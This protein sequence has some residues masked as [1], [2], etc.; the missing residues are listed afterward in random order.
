[1]A[2][3]KVK[4]IYK[5]QGCYKRQCLDYSVDR[6]WVPHRRCD[7]SQK[8]SSH[9]L[10]R[11]TNDCPVCHKSFSRSAALMCHIR[12]NHSYMLSKKTGEKG[13]IRSLKEDVMK[14][15][16]RIQEKK[17]SVSYDE[18]AIDVR[19]SGTDKDSGSEVSTCSSGKT[20]DGNEGD[21]D[22][23]SDDFAI[24]GGSVTSV[25][26]PSSKATSSIVSFTSSN[27]ELL[28]PDQSF[29]IVR[30]SS[31][32]DVK[33]KK[34]KQHRS[35]TSFNKDTFNK[36]NMSC[37]SLGIKAALDFASID[38]SIDNSSEDQKIF[39]C[40][41]C[42]D[43]F[44]SANLLTYHHMRRHMTS[45]LQQCSDCGSVFYDLSLFKAHCTIH[46][47]SSRVKTHIRH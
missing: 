41:V 42:K 33:M 29:S 3:M 20:N 12:Q 38:F 32:K 15:K 21:L 8:L 40:Y 16:N 25:G 28:D 37:E 1:M 27:A 17:S 2:G 35:K 43:S 34:G 44:S 13:S 31:K 23:D 9:E 14:W 30:Q 39:E 6:D 26:N 4:S 7:D 47:K 19:S 22:Q 5:P 36:D 11:E 10:E 46:T 45:D 24:I 18:A